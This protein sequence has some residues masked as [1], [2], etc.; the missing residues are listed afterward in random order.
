[1]AIDKKVA[2]KVNP[3]PQSA[4]NPN[5][6]KVPDTGSMPSSRKKGGASM[7]SSMPST[8]KRSG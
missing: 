1:M 4:R 5:P 8:G 6:G 7:G 3:L 2:N